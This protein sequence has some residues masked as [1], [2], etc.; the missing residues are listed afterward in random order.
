VDDIILEFNQTV[1]SS[2]WTPQ[3][4]VLLVRTIKQLAKEEAGEWS[5]SSMAVSPWAPYNIPVSTLV[6]H[7]EQVAKEHITLNPLVR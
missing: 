2:L 5:P 4:D 6:L 7:F 1:Q 3:L